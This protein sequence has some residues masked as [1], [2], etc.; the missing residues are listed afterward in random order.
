MFDS[1]FKKLALGLM[2]LLLAACGEPEALP[3]PLQSSTRS[4]SHGGATPCSNGR[5]CRF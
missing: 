3:P 4:V 1:I 2:V 5:C